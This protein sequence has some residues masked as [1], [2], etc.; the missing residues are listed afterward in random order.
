MADFL[1]GKYLQP[2]RAVLLQDWLRDW[3]FRNPAA[4]TSKSS[5]AYLDGQI[6]VD[7][8]L[9]LYAY[10][11]RVARGTNWVNSSGT[12]LDDWIEAIT[13]EG[14]LPAVGAVGFVTIGAS[15]GGTTIQAGDQGTCNGFTYRALFTGLYQNGQAVAVQ[16]V[17][18]GP[19]TDQPAGAAFTWSVPRPGCSP[20]ASVT[21]Q[22]DGTGL[23]G[24][25]NI[26]SDAEAKIRLSNYRSDPPG[27]GNDAHYRRTLMRQGSLGAQAIFTYPACLFPGS[28]GVAFTLRPA[29]PGASRI[30]N[31][32]QMQIALQ[33]LQYA[34]PAS[35]AIFMVTLLPSPLAM[36]FKAL[37]ATGAPGWADA[38]PFPLYQSPGNNWV[39]TN[40]VVPTP[41]SFNI[42]SPTDATVPQA[43]Q[44]IGFF[45]VVGQVFRRKRI[46]SA[47]AA[48]GGYTIVVDTT[49]AV[50]DTSFA[51]AVGDFV[52]PWSDS[53]DSM[54]DPVLAYFD[55]LGPGEQQA[56]FFD[57]GQRQK[58][59]PP[60]PASW[61]SQI[62][63]RMLGGPPNASQPP[64][65][66]APATPTLLATPNLADVEI[67]EPSLPFATPVGSPGVSAYLLTLGGL[68]VFPET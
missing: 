2:T 65:P 52:S 55:S 10:A 7:Q 14:R 68:A 45:D 12:D 63:N 39:I 33:S 38:S 11:D 19:Q 23:T 16:G 29:S 49:N 48:S 42:K 54:V 60:N 57:K 30:P 32:A 24:G 62:A 47:T 4:D 61:A 67:V 59:M 31:A 43:G 22:P 44:N 58:R 35:D 27:S 18:T 25:R 13:G 1:P 3:T 28:T 41:T 34:M 37:W 21:L 66:N 53:L 64:D 15:S 56:S 50:S 36:V 26:E 20:K 8:T 9:P 51:P 6:H 40:A 17:D 46:L 5:Q